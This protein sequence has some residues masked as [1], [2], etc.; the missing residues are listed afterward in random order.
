MLPR[1]A[2]VS[3]STVARAR[4]TRT[5]CHAGTQLID[6]PLGVVAEQGLLANPDR[7]RSSLK[8]RG[9]TPS[10]WLIFLWLS[11]A[12]SWARRGGRRS[13][14]SLGGRPRSGRRSL[15]PTPVGACCSRAEDQDGRAAP[16][17]WSAVGVVAA[18]VPGGPGW[19]TGPRSGELSVIPSPRVVAGMVRCDKVRG[20]RDQSDGATAPAGVSPGLGS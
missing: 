20:E 14:G 18:P 10:L 5:R 13:Q 9:S 7:G 8:E 11:C 19:W 3:R 2:A 12:C 4:C 15:T 17:G 6:H 16:A 1:L